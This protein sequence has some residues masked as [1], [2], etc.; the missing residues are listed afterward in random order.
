MSDHLLPPNSALLERKLAT[1]IK[2]LSDIPVPVRDVWDPGSCPIEVLPW[3]AW[4][5]SVDEWDPNWTDAQKRQTVQS[6][7]AVHRYKGTI[8]AVEEALSALGYGVQVQEWFNQSPPGDPYTFKLLLE[9][10]DVGITPA[11]IAKAIAVALDAKNLRSHLESFDVRMVTAGTVYAASAIVTGND[12]TIEYDGQVAGLDG[13]AETVIDRH[14]DEPTPERKIAINNL[15]VTL[16]DLGI[17]TK[18]DALFISLMAMDQAASCIDWIRPTKTA[19]ING[20]ASWVDTHGFVGDGVEGSYIDFDFTPSTDGVNYTLHDCSIGCYITAASAQTECAY[21]GV[22]LSGGK[23]ANLRRASS[24]S[25][26]FC[27]LNQ[28]I[29]G[30]A[31]H[32]ASLSVANKL[33]VADRHGAGTDT[34]MY[35]YVNG[36]ETGS[37][38]FVDASNLPDISIQGL[39]QST[40]SAPY[41]QLASTGKMGVWYAGASLT[42]AEQIA[43]KDAIDAYIA[44][45]S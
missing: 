3:L 7:I 5:L 24:G 26:H 35:L 10:Y 30:S 42:E 20:G 44:E 9:V 8:G 12:I 18:L 15:V 2:R 1:A 43:F 36:V 33:I 11:G 21:W 14:E 32:N 29:G 23:V 6:S 45:L 31:Y 25:E 37:S 17:Y 34:D 41:T 40:A 4:A 38:D 28:T 16:K 13:D 22:S 39:A 27:V 19:T